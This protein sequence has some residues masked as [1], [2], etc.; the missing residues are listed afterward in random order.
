MVD[1]KNEGTL[2]ELARDPTQLVVDKVD[3]KSARRLQQLIRGGTPEV[4]VLAT[5]AI[6]RTGNLDYVPTLLYALTD[7]EPRV[8]IEARN[9]LR[10]I[11]RNFDG[12]G[13]PDNFTEQQRFEAIDN[14]KR[15]YKSIRPTAIFEK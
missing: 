5:R 13:P 10:F 8:V 6:G 1:D 7:P 4:R 14:W 9:G 12:L 11:S 2:D 15:W 3:E